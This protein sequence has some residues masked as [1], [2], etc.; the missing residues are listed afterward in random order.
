MVE[1]GG[2]AEGGA[3]SDEHYREEKGASVEK[4][5]KKLLKP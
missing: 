3:V 4:A 2:G 5:Q 1:T